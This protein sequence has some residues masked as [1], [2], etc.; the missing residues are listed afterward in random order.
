MGKNR[1][2]RHPE[3]VGDPIVETRAL[4]WSA[5]GPLLTRYGQRGSSTRTTADTSQRCRHATFGA[6]HAGIPSPLRSAAGRVGLRSDIVNENT[7]AE[8]NEPSVTDLTAISAPTGSRKCIR[9]VPMKTK[10]N[11][12]TAWGS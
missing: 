10:S 8:T 12:P 6:H 11:L 9:T 5:P 1:Q 7:S 3:P 2:V 4:D